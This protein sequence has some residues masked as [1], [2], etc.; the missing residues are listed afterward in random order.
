MFNFKNIL[1]LGLVAVIAIAIFLFLM[2]PKKVGAMSIVVDGNETVLNGGF[3][4]GL[5]GWDYW[6]GV[7]VN[8][9]AYSGTY[10]AKFDS[11]AMIM[12]NITLPTFTSALFNSYYKIESGGKLEIF[13]V[14]DSGVYNQLLFTNNPGDW[15]F[16]SS[17]ITPYITGVNNINVGCIMMNG[18]IDNVI[19]SSPPGPPVPEPTTIGLFGLGLIGIARRYGLIGQKR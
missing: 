6:G 15:C 19:P 4:F 2:S 17:N 13:M 16:F 14:D 8:S 12:Q 9:T 7:N 18:M 5:T 11:L 3:E 1:D 10:A